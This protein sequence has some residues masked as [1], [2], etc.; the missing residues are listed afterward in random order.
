MA[1]IPDLSG[2]VVYVA[3]HTGMVG[4]ALVRRL[5]PRR[6]RGRYGGRMRRSTSAMRPG[7]PVRDDYGTRRRFCRGGRGRR[8]AANAARP[9]RFLEDNLR[10][11]VNV[12]SAAA[13]AKVEKLVFPRFPPASTRERRRSRSGKTRC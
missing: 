1:A 2:K 12:I 10:I 6:L 7:A 13:E 8:I 4:S 3:G 11:S 5:E 9:V